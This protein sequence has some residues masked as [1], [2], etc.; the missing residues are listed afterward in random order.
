MNLFSKIFKSDIK[1]MIHAEV[2]RYSNRGTMVNPE[3]STYFK[4]TRGKIK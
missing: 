1:S 2:R 3:N 4:D